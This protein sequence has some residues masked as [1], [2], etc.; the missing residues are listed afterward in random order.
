MKPNKT[1]PPSRLRALAGT[2]RLTTISL[3]I[4]LGVCESSTGWTQSAGTPP[5]SQAA[6][7]EAQAS[8]QLQEVTVTGTYLNNRDSETPSP[9]TVLTAVDMI[10]R[11]FTNV[12]DAVRSVSAD[13]SGTI[14]TSTSSIFPVG[15]SGVALR[16]LT[17]A[18]TLVLIDGLRTS[19][20]PL[21][22]DGIRSFVDLN[23][24]P[25]GIVDRVEVLKDGASSIYGSDAVGGVVNIITK[26]TFSGLQADA[27]VGDSEHGGG[28]EKR[29][30]LLIGHGD[31][32]SD[33][34]NGYLELEYQGDDDI[35]VGQRGF[36]FN[37][38]NL[39]SIGGFNGIGGQPGLGSGSIYGSVTPATLSTPGNLL[40]GVPLPGAVSQPLRAC[41]PGTQ[42][43]VDGSGN[44]YCAQNLS[45]YGDDQ[46]A[47]QRW[48]VDGRLTRQLNDS[49]EVWLNVYYYQNK[50]TYSEQPA[51]VQNGFQTNTTTIALPPT[52]TNGALN[53]NNPFAPLGQYAL[54]NYAFGDLP[55]ALQE[56][57]HVVRGV[58]GLK[59]EAL[60][61]S[62][63]ADLTA[64]HSSL[65]TTETG[66]LDSDQLLTDIADGGYSFINPGSNSAATLAA[67]APPINRTST[68]DMDSIDAHASRPLVTL[69][70]GPL[71]LALGGQYRYE[72]NLQP[73]LN[74]TD[75]T[76]LLIYQGVPAIATDGHRT[77]GAGFVE[78]DAPII[79]ELDVDVAGRYDH[80]SDFG[81]AFSPKYGVKFTPIPQVSFRGTYAQGFRAPSFSEDGS[82]S[83]EG[84][85]SY[86]PAAAPAGTPLANFANAHGND[87]YVQPYN[88]VEYTVANPQIKPEHSRSFT[89]GVVLDP[90]DVLHFSLDYYQ[91]LQTDLIAPLGTASV[92][93]D[94]YS[95]TALPQGSSVVLDSADPAYPGALPRVEVVEAPYVNAN[96]LTTDGVDLDLRLTFA[97]P[98]NIRLVSELNA[99][100]ILHFDFTS[101][102]TTYDYVGTQSPYNLSSGAGTPQYRANWSNTL[103][104]GPASLTGSLYYTSGIREY[105]LDVYGPGVCAYTDASGNP[106]PAGCKVSDFFDFDL[107]GSYQLSNGVQ[108]YANILNLFDAKPPLDPPDYA[109]VNYNPTYEQQG[110]V[111][112]FFRVGVRVKL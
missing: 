67:L 34:W 81:G 85:V 66:F 49:T 101:S 48:G 73:D 45:L 95:G 39:S 3:A 62:Y 41:G 36:P 42:Q 24:I 63:E 10:N 64:A 74:T 20:Y 40:T 57:D 71:S 7:D 88:L 59:G 6:S 18:D 2:L 55:S 86:D 8:S 23:T 80:Y 108:L 35:Q 72:A 89:L 109:G 78:L 107:T 9:I 99:T 82:S 46:P 50:A 77:V 15:A 92:L 27:S 97:L 26:R 13:N 106:Y 28:F 19:D 83:T 94:Y 110:I 37:T 102:G 79:K 60:S 32:N 44:V 25:M 22:D 87:A 58:L 70:G 90:L 47:Q 33:G 51:Q 75:A 11:G 104:F 84:Y 4:I 53:P 112:R 14:P 103:T 5:A 68:Y 93:N 61:W 38:A 1:A 91:I 54:L 29:A 17:A 98:Y 16:G 31:L 56:D 69:P 21:P 43:N 65:D 30:N 105:V 52:L 96:S 12:S 111:G 76:G 100:D